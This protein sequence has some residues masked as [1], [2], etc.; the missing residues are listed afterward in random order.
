VTAALTVLVLGIV[1]L[2]D[3]G[4]PHDRV[5]SSAES[6]A[7][8]TTAGLLTTTTSTSVPA[9]TSTTAP[10]AEPEPEPP[11]PPPS[12]P[13]DAPEAQCTTVI[14]EGHGPRPDWAFW[15]QTEPGYNDPLTLEVC[16]S[17]VT[18]GPGDIVTIDVAYADPDAPISGMHPRYGLCSPGNGCTA[19]VDFGNG[20][21][22]GER[23]PGWPSPPTR[24]VPTPP[25]FPGE[26]S[27]P[28]GTTYA[29]PG[30][31]VL[32]VVAYSVDNAE[33]TTGSPYASSAEA[34]I[35]VTVG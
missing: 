1:A 22:R 21:T 20:D 34:T 4:D 23:S 25:E 24:P 27:W 8:L 12:P 29:E 19:F 5:R 10:P 15:W 11:A 2:P 14:G 7:T 26:T 18:P 13:V 28:T 6:P 9:T 30:S 31:Y 3:D 33:N 35:V 32:T 16:V 17:D